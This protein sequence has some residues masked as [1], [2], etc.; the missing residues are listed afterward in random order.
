M[1]RVEREADGGREAWTDL[2]EIAQAR[3][4]PGLS[5]FQCEVYASGLAPAIELEDNLQH[6]PHTGVDRVFDTNRT[7]PN[8][9]LRADFVCALDRDIEIPPGIRDYG[10]IGIERHMHI[11]FEVERR[12][13]NARGARR[14]GVFPERV[15]RV[16]PLV[17]EH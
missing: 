7:L 17:I 16:L 10:R 14:S 12:N 13:L 2:D 9:G 4:Y 15:G 1:M 5:I 8:D 6:R 11:R 3:Q